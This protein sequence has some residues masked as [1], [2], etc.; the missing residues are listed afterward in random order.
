[1]KHCANRA[2][3]KK[4]SEILFQLAEVTNILG[5]SSMRN[6]E[7]RSQIGPDHSIGSWASPSNYLISLVF[8]INLKLRVK[9]Q[10]F[11][12]DRPQNLPYTY[13]SNFI[14]KEPLCS[15]FMLNFSKGEARQRKHQKKSNKWIFSILFAKKGENRTSST[16]YDLES[17]S[18]TGW[19]FQVSR[20]RHTLSLKMMII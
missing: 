12:L 14:S 11:F 2:T 3:R 17:R 8:I 13:C 20:A 5:H 10:I 19:H 15:P 7:L 6:E 18:R 4:K 9:S 1:M 16:L